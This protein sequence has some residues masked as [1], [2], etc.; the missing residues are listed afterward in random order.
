MC[1]IY[2]ALTNPSQPMTRAELHVLHLPKFHDFKV[3]R[4]V[5]GFGIELLENKDIAIFLHFMVINFIT[6]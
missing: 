2:E 3:I 6:R 5:S 4:H 1:L